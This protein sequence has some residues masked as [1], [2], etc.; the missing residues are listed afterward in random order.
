MLCSCLVL[1]TT[2]MR[3]YWP[4]LYGSSAVNDGLNLFCSM[5]C[6][7]AGIPIPRYSIASRGGRD[8]ESWFPAKN[9]QNSGVRGYRVKWQRPRAMLRNFVRN[10]I[11]LYGEHGKLST[12]VG[13]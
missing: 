2:R 1:T 6:I 7:F 10:L 3:V 9:R 11:I 5:L 12:A 8:S 4:F 13:V